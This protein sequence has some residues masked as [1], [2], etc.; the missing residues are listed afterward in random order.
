M[1][2]MRRKNESV[3]NGNVAG[4]K[5]TKRCWAELRRATRRSSGPAHS[6][7]GDWEASREG[8]GAPVLYYWKTSSE[9]N[10]ENNDSFRFLPGWCNSGLHGPSNPVKWVTVLGKLGTEL[11]LQLGTVSDPQTP[12]PPSFPSLPTSASSLLSL[13]GGWTQ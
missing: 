4:K 7:D 5:K 13:W 12:G 10:R 2:C 11:N 9:T 3:L 1:K 6:Q 8:W